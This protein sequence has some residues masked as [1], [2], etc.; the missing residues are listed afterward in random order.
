MCENI[1]DLPICF[2]QKWANDDANDADDGLMN[3]NVDFAPYWNKCE[4]LSSRACVT[5]NYTLNKLYLYAH[6][7]CK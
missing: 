2:F 4:K 5:L 6:E 3:I 1:D 7:I